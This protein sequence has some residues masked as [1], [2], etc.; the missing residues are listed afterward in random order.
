MT[1][2]ETIFR[3]IRRNAMVFMDSHYYREHKHD[4]DFNPAVRFSMDDTD[5][6]VS[7][8]TVNDVQ[9]QLDRYVADVKRNFRF[10][11]IGKEELLR[12]A[13]IVALVRTGIADG[14]ERVDWL[15]G[16]AS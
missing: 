15:K 3:N 1:K 8:R 4:T 7:Q 14:Q 10:G 6:F 5:G 16:L 9:R 13:D 2:A 11:V 12:E